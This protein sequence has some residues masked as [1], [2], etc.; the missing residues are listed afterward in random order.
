MPS[1]GVRD[2]CS[3]KRSHDSCILVVIHQL[4][5]RMFNIYWIEFELSD[6]RITEEIAAKSEELAIRH[7]TDG[8]DISEEYITD[9]TLVGAA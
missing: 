6:E 3:R 8:Y 4:E 2:Q 5:F 9:I 7:I 1:D